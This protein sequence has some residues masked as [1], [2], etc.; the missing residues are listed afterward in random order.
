MGDEGTWLDIQGH[1]EVLQSELCRSDAQNALLSEASRDSYAIKVNTPEGAGPPVARRVSPAKRATIA[2]DEH[3]N[4]TSSPLSRPSVARSVGAESA[5]STGERTLPQG[6]RPP[7]QPKT[8]LRRLR[9]GVRA[10]KAIVDIPVEELDSDRDHGSEADKSPD[11]GDQAQRRGV[12]AL[13]STAAV[14]ARAQTKLSIL[15]PDAKWRRWWDCIV[16]LFTFFHGMVAPLVVVG[17]IDFGSEIAAVH[18]FL[19]CIW[20]VDVLIHSQTAFATPDGVLVT[21]IADVRSRYL[22]RMMWADVASAPPYD[23]VLWWSGAPYAAVRATAGLRIGRLWHVFNL[24]AQSNPAIITPQYVTFNFTIAPRLVSIFWGAMALHALVVIKLALASDEDSRDDRYD[25][26]LF[27]VWNLLTTSPAPLT[28]YNYGQRLLCFSLMILGVFFQGVIIGKVSYVLLKNSIRDENI[29]TMRTTLRFIQQY[30]VPRALQQE[31]LSL[32]WHNL[33]SSLSAVGRSQILESLPPVMRTE[34]LLYIKIDFIDKV[35]MFTNAPHKTKVLLADSLQQMYFEPGEYIIRVGEVGEEMYFILHGYCAVLVP[36]LGLVAQFNRGECFGELALLTQDKRTASVR[37]LTYCDCLRLLK[38]DFERV[39]KC[40]PEFEKLILE[41]AQRRV[42]QAT[43]RASAAPG[44]PRSPANRALL[45]RGISSDFGKRSRTAAFRR[46]STR[47][48]GM[49]SSQSEREMVHVLAAEQ[50]K[51]RKK[52]AAQPLEQL[53][54][55]LR[56]IDGGRQTIQRATS[57]GLSASMVGDRS[58]PNRPASAYNSSK[59]RSI[60]SEATTTSSVMQT[61]GAAPTS[62]GTSG[63][64]TSSMAS[65][66]NPLSTT[67]R[68]SQLPPQAEEWSSFKREWTA[69]SHQAPYPHDGEGSPTNIASA[70]NPGAPAS[71]QAAGAATGHGFPTFRTLDKFTF[72]T[73]ASAQSLVQG[74]ASS[75]SA[76]TLAI[77]GPTPR[78]PHLSQDGAR[79]VPPVLMSASAHSAAP[80]RRP[81]ELRRASSLPHISPVMADLGLDRMASGSSAAAAPD[82]TATE[83][84][85]LLASRLDEFRADMVGMVRKLHE[86]QRRSFRETREALE[87]LNRR[88]TVLQLL[89]E[90][91]I[92]HRVAQDRLSVASTSQVSGRSIFGASLRDRGGLADIAPRAVHRS[93]GSPPLV[94]TP[95][96]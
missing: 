39:C 12:E 53:L 35:P 85:A 34:I 90:A 52:S 44:S 15:L 46:P 75:R 18:I 56:D 58:P 37:A 41:E 20:C 13:T 61:D 25:Y 23:A 9:M 6:S 86:E 42:P 89:N 1:G 24:F 92:R 71:T 88:F 54:G 21:D 50:I 8:L 17:N 26:A 77:S 94:T 51:M 95:Q 65:I 93:G 76:P 47:T 55:V 68:R 60:T 28:L 31:V 48:S 2:P 67:G 3:L 73:S 4:P 70:P 69:V 45:A 49:S 16:L 80:P 87:D 66:G 64:N 5:V 30:K 27:W 72:T 14:V 83:G 96:L 79:P 22:R 10:L 29:E 62:S 33:Q 81:G 82:A 19:S 43:R 84:S 36:G 7:Q 91:D 57:G 63:I 11:N 40:N 32:Q 74:A 38:D 59:H 78:M